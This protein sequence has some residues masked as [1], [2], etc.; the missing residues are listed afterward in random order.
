M[1]W[2]CHDKSHS[3]SGEDSLE[4]EDFFGMIPLARRI[5]Q[6]QIAHHA[7]VEVP[8]YPRIQKV[9][10]NLRH[11]APGMHLDVG[12]SKGGFA[13]DRKSTRLNSSHRTIS[14]AVF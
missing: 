5:K 2:L 10:R 13:E 6:L 8:D 9:V 7:Q 1:R 3:I 11:L 12:Y 4:L 14:Y